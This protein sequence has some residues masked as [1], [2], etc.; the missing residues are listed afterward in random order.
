MAA[1]KQFAL[2]HADKRFNVRAVQVANPAA[3][4]DWS[5]AVPNGMAWRPRAIFFQ[6]VTSA[7]VATRQV[8]VV[9]KDDQGNIVAEFAASGSQAASLTGAYTAM[10]GG[11]LA[12]ANNVFV[13]PLPFDVVLPAAFT[14]GTSTGSIQA[15]DQYSLINL[16]VEETS[17]LM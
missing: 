11:P 1:A 10:Q 6:L 16:L 9:I 7:T 2:T 3:G 15:A 12:G 17:Q 4:A 14:I 8:N 13:M 5:Q